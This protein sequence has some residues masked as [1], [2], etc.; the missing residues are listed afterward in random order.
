MAD[1]AWKD[2]V[3]R[4]SDGKT[5]WMWQSTEEWCSWTALCASHRT[6]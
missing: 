2:T 4:T 5:C 3:I 6:D 1:T